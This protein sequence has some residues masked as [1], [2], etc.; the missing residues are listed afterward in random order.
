[1]PTFMYIHFKISLELKMLQV[2]CERPN[3]FFFPITLS[4]KLEKY[5]FT[6]RGRA[7]LL[8]THYSGLG[9]ISFLL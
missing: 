1:M 4:L 5:H 9:S 7:T 2:D 3:H 6:I 8:P